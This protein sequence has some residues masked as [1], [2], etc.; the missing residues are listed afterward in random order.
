MKRRFYRPRSAMAVVAALA[1]S[2]GVLSAAPAQ[3]SPQPPAV[4]RNVTDTYVGELT[5]EQL[6]ILNGSGIDRQEVIV[7]PGR[8]GKSHVEA[9]MT[10]LT[11]QELIARGVP[12][13]VKKVKGKTASEFS[14]QTHQRVFRPYSGPGNIREEIVKL[15]AD[16]SGIAK[17][18]DIGRTVQGK[19]ITAVRVSKGVAQ[20]RDRQR[21]AVV[22]QAA[23]HAREWITPE[24]VRRLLHHYVENYGKNAEITKIVDTTDVWFVP[25]VNV[26]GYDFTFTGRNRLWRKNLR[27]NDGDGQITA[28]DGV[29]LN[30][31]FP[32]KWGFDNEGSADDPTDETFRGKGP[33]SEP[34]TKAQIALFERLRPKFAVNYHS[35]AELLL[36]GVG[37]QTLTQSP[38]DLI[39]QALVGNV[40]RPA[41]PGSTPQLGAQLYTT[42]GDTDGQMDNNTGTLTISP[43]MSTCVSASRVD[44]NDEWDPAACPSIFVFPDDETLVQGEFAKNLSFALATAKSA[45]DPENPVSPVGAT[46]PD[47]QPDKFPVS[48]GSGTQEAASLVRRSLRDKRMNYRINGG[49]AQSTPVH[50]WRGGSRFGDENRIYFA[51]YRGTVRGQKAGDRVEVW[52]SGTKGR[53]RV[54]SEHFTYQVRDAKGADVVVV[55]EEDYKGVNP[56]YPQGTNAPKY[57]QQYLDDIK[58]NKVKSLVWDIDKDGVPHDLGVLKH[59]DAAVWYVGDNRLTQDAADEVVPTTDGPFRDSQV[60][61][62]AL[63]L[64]LN[65]RSYMNEG[66]KLLYTGETA[67]YFGPLR[68]RN[69]GGIYYGLKGHT[70]RPCV[71]GTGNFR[72]DCELLSNDFMQYYLG[73]WDREPI[74]NPTGLA[75]EADPFAKVNVGLGGAAD[76]P[77]NEAGGLEVTSTRLPSK[78]FPLFRSWKAADYVGVVGPFEPPEGASYIAGTHRDNLYRRLTRTIDLSSVTAAQAPELRSQLSFSTETG[79][80]HVIV[81][82][83]TQGAEDWTTLPDKNGRTT[84]RVPTQCEQGFLMEGHPFLSHYLTQGNPCANTGSSGKWNSFTGSSGGWVPT[85]FDLSAYAGKKVEVSISYVSDPGSGG[86]GLFIDDTKLVTSA[87]QIDAEGFES[88]LGPWMIQGAPEGSDPNRSEFVRSQALIDSVAAVATKNSVVLGVGIEQVKTPAERR[89]LIGRALDQLLD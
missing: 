61:D 26:D 45:Q 37:W 24:M 82:A 28:Q 62:R 18:V 9:V 78:Q 87:G 7:T 71:V 27:D 56:V 60:A 20:L 19:P 38:D 40:D 74:S 57:A 70:D 42:N 43:E 47:F 5:S 73:V 2:I 35:A 14:A 3:A 79:F 23:Q 31:N 11:A 30:R 10:G 84:D 75:G 58:A 64:M 48:Y 29:D 36:H 53:S 12:L 80:D 83:H 25:V 34:E 67:A 16:N 13:S 89:E 54:D 86:S 41:V 81:E 72:D 50:E 55:A 39:H 6:G 15:A 77:L 22:Y 17:A 65:M 51:E 59:F 88:G 1:L 33:A 68:E 85:A 44:P 4:Q 66:G 32:Y 63:D 52:F 69:G 21:P 76:N 8:G 46:V 49:R